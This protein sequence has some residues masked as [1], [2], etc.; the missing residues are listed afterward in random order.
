M[1][2]RV[3]GRDPETG[4]G[5]AVSIAD[6]R[7]TG[8]EPTDSAGTLYLSAGLIDLQINGYL[9]HDL[10]DGTVTPERVAALTESQLALGT[11]T[12]LP[13]FVTNSETNITNGLLAVRTA[14]QHYPRVASAVPAVHVEGPFISPHDGARGAHQAEHVRDADSAEFDRWQAASGGLVGLLTLSPH[15]DAAIALVRHASAAGV[16]VAL[17]HTDATTEQ[18]H[19][20]AEAGAT[21]STHLGNGISAMLA[22]HP[23][24]I[25]AQLADDRLTA[26]LIGDGHHLPADTLK[27]MLRAKGLDKALLVSDIV[28]PGGLEPG[29]YH[30]T[31]GGRVQLWA[32]GRLGPPGTPYL[33]GAAL[34]LNHDVAR[35]V[36]MTGLSLAQVLRL[37]T[38]NPGR[39]AGGRGKLTVGE[40]ADLILFDWQPGDEMLAI[41]ETYLEGELAW[42][43]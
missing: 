29:I 4:N 30:Q 16:H 8:I 26:T 12:Y 10:N 13:T 2:A 43:R 38:V 7:I 1:S 11:T 14:R 25:W 28:S 18:I 5:I 22:R 6:G 23:N 35:T 3:V 21:L 32:N 34:P 42:A 20:A 41:A 33:A 40:R 37:A 17:G 9:H 19:A 31:I 15:S 36:T 39:F 24:P 27:T